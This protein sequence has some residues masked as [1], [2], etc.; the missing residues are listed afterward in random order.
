MESLSSVGSHV[1][2]EVM[3]CFVLGST[4]LFP[5]KDKRTWFDEV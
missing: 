4:K 5:V 3:T 1:S 2:L